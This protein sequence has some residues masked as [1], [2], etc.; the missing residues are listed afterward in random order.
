MNYNLKYDNIMLRPLQD[1]DLENLRI[2]R[3]D[4][5]KNQYLKKISFISKDSQCKWYNDYLNNET[6]I[7]FAI[8]EIKE[9]HRLVGSIALYNIKDN[10]AE[11]GRIQVGDDEAHCK[12][13]GKN[14]VAL[15]SKFAFEECHIKHLL[16]T[17]NKKNVASLKLF[18]DSG[19]RIIEEKE[20]FSK[21]GG[22]DYVLE[23]HQNFTYD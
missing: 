18:L 3:N 17:V 8:D 22:I 4:K 15:L 14:A 2:W 12:K 21:A 16:A 5:K 20:S 1:G 13:I 11:I 9:L 6:E 23:K 10:C 19:Y 7:I